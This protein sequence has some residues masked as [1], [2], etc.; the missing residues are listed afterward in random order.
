MIDSGGTPSPFWRG[1]TAKRGRAAFMAAA[2]AEDDIAA[3]ER[4][5]C[6]QAQES[7]GHHGG[8]C[9]GVKLLLRTRGWW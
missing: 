5:A 9:K 7:M 4:G 8:G 1:L 6:A 3:G 2:A